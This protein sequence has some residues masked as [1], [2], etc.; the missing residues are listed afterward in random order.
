M[1]ADLINSPPE[2]S[3]DVAILRALI[4]VLPSQ[5][6][7]KALK[8]ISQVMEPGSSIY[9]V[10]SVLDDTRLSPIAS[11]AFS[12]VFLNVYDDGK[13]YTEKEHRDLLLE[14]G[15]VDISIEH[16]AMSDGLGI[17]SARK[18]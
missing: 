13:S 12:L 17:V 7:K 4:Q 5:Y 9:I 2:G 1:A 6:A 16:N 11:V 8:N 14:A 10:G 3:Y 18:S 15:F